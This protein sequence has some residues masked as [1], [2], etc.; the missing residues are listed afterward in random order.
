MQAAI[1]AGQGE[2]KVALCAIRSSKPEFEET[3]TKRVEGIL[4]SVDQRKQIKGENAGRFYVA[5]AQ[6]VIRRN[7]NCNIA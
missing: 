6:N 7:R 1:I 5:G 4:A 2:I 3:I